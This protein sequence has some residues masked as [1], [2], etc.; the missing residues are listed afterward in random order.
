MKVLL[1]KSLVVFLSV[2]IFFAAVNV[3]VAPTVEAAPLIGLGSPSG[4]G[5]S[6]SNP[7]PQSG[8]GGTL[9]GYAFPDIGY[10]LYQ[11]EQTLPHLNRLVSIT[12]YLLGF[13]MVFKALMELRKYGEARTMMSNNADLKGPVMMLIAGTG[14]LFFPSMIDTGLQTLFGTDSILVYYTQKGDLFAQA[15]NVL[16]GIVWLVGAIAFLRG[17]M[18]FYK[19]G[20]NQAEQKAGPR[21]VSHLIG[22][23]LCLNIVAT[24]NVIYSTLGIFGN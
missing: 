12:A 8:Q 6:G 15:R 5:N 14:C 13:F 24:K 18:L 11:I 10:T 23:I 4:D 2:F 20:T 17:L 9:W 1:S 21:A 22:G 3:A 7:P 19:T 16:I